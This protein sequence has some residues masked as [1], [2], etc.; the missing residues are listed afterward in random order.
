MIAKKYLALLLPLA[1]AC[2]AP[3]LGG[4]MME[5]GYYYGHPHYGRPIIVRHYY[6]P[7]RHHMRF[8]MNDGSNPNAND[9]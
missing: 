9:G 1:V 3:L 5:G 8:G 6:A 2:L 4:C 7:H